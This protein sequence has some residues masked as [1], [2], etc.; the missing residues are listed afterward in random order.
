MSLL[1]GLAEYAA[2]KR[3]EQT[4]SIFFLGV[5]LFLW[6][7]CLGYNLCAS[8]IVPQLCA[9]SEDISPDVRT[10]TALSFVEVSNTVGPSITCSRLLVPFHRLAS[11]PEWSVR[12]GFL[13]SLLGVSQ[14]IPP[15]RSAFE[16]IPLLRQLLT[17]SNRL[18]K[19]SA[20]RVL[21]PFI[22]TLLDPRLIPLDLVD[23][24]LSLASLEADN[25]TK[26]SAS[27]RRR[28]AVDL[29]ALH[30]SAS[31]LSR[32]SSNALLDDSFSISLQNDSG[33]PLCQQNTISDPSALCAYSFAAVLWTLCG[34]GNGLCKLRE[35]TAD[36]PISFDRSFHQIAGHTKDNGI[37]T[38]VAG[39]KSRYLAIASFSFSESCAAM[40]GQDYWWAV[41]RP[42]LFTLLNS[43]GSNLESNVG[44]V[45]RL[46]LSFH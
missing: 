29:L 34:R 8:F 16:F 40:G 2:P 31:L 39:E 24:Y 37:M 20:Q 21:G 1:S 27:D 36:R 23:E 5:F 11:D 30:C 41:F 7:R 42:A 43:R 12:K 4:F 32:S 25:A 18:V 44:I 17:D 3:E 15:E 26:L 19:L 38:P 45:L 33:S 6:F 13:E 9:L 46:I 14:V 10:A 22:S 35:A 28:P